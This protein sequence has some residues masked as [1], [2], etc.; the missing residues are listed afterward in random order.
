MKTI[1]VSDEVYSWLAEHKEYLESEGQHPLTFDEVIR[2]LYEKF[3]QAVEALA[4][5]RTR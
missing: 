5:N 3:H 1:E 2:D 4:R